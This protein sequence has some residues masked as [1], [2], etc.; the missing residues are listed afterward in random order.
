MDI[1]NQ[2][3]I[4]FDLYKNIKKCGSWTVFTVMGD[5]V[6]VAP[7]LLCARNS[8]IYMP[9]SNLLAFIVSEISAFIRTDGQTD[10]ARSTIEISKHTHHKNVPRL[11]Y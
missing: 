8:R 3:N 11:N 1:N 6:G 9:N 2:N 5:K 7:C 4:S 10:M